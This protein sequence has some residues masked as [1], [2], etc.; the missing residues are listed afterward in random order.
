MY[1]VICIMEIKIKQIDNGWILECFKD[2]VVKELKSGYKLKGKVIVAAK[3][4]LSE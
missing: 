2:K 4:E 1:N 3:V